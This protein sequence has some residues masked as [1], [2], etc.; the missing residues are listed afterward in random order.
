MNL[1][2]SQ[3]HVLFHSPGPRWQAG[4]EPRDQEGIEQHYAFVGRLAAEWL[5]VLAG[6][7]LDAENGGMV[8]TRI[9]SPEEAQRRANEDEAVRSGVLAVR[10]RP[11]RVVTRDQA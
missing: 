8:L 6:P 9:E 11:W 4:V 3:L 10:V 5:V 1:P 7:F 2:A